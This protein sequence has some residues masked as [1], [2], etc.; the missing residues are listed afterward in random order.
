MIGSI[1]DIHVLLSLL[2]KHNSSAAFDHSSTQLLAQGLDEL[3]ASSGVSAGPLASLAK[4]T[5]LTKGF[6][7]TQIWQLF[8][9]AAIE[10]LGESEAARALLSAISQTSD[11]GE[12]S[13]HSSA[14]NGRQR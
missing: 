9:S 8:R 4:S 7:Q 14:G 3:A 1:E 12:S 13:A 5:A 11:Q 10:R 6:G 2:E